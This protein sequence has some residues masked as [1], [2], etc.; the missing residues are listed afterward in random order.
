MVVWEWPSYPY[1]RCNILLIFAK[2]NVGIIG[3]RRQNF[4]EAL[5]RKGVCHATRLP[6]PH[7]TK[8]RC[9]ICS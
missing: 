8:C 6:N 2:A 9:I 7:L 5:A 4:W 1:L 3:D